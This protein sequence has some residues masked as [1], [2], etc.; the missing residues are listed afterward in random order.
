MAQSPMGA[1]TTM[2]PTSPVPT[3]V[4]TATV[5]PASYRARYPAPPT[6][7][8][9]SEA[10]QDSTTAAIQTLEHVGRSGFQTSEFWAVVLAPMISFLIAMMAGIAV[11][12]GLVLDSQ[13]QVLVPT[14]SGALTASL[15]AWAAAVYARGRSDLKAAMARMIGDPLRR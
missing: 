9:A 5:D 4:G 1:P 14:V 15:S 10:F 7:A 8:T 3:G 13:A 2:P 6:P 11:T 12:R